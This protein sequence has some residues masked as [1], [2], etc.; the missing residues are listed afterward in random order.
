MAKVGYCRIT[1]LRTKFFYQKDGKEL[2]F[3]IDRDPETGLADIWIRPT[4]TDMEA[5]TSL[6]GELLN[7]WQVAERK[8]E[9]LRKKE[10]QSE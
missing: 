1:K 9:K 8:A 3:Y 4:W 6:F 10:L 7:E 2:E 5:I